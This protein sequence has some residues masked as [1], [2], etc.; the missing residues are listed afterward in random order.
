MRR[1]TPPTTPPTGTPPAP[2]PGAPPAG[3][4]TLLARWESAVDRGIEG[5]E[6]EG[7]LD[8]LLEAL[9]M[10]VA[11][12]AIGELSLAAPARRDALR[13]TGARALLQLGTLLLPRS[14]GERT[15]EADEERAE[16]VR[17]VAPYARDGLRALAGKEPARGPSA[18]ESSVGDAELVGLVRGSFDGFRLA[19][20]AW[21]VRDSREAQRALG[22]MCRLEELSSALE[23]GAT[24]RTKRA[25]GLR[26]AA[27]GSSS[28]R[29][30]AE[31]RRIAELRVGSHDV[32]LFRFEDHVVA[33]YAGTTV[34][35]R[36][37]GLHVTP[38]VT[39]AGYAEAR[40]EGAATRVELEVGGDRATLE[41]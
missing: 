28:V 27:D 16:A 5:F 2:P 21:R 39:R 8:G 29:D 24:A 3:A 41:L 35:L 40:L 7:Q 33:A 20:I 11:L 32:E 12:E 25:A 26:L 19:E 14:E 31:G 23:G 6:G 18:V 10:T 15:T 1:K 4:S 38:L 36:L 30:P 13:R 34:V 22:L 17:I 9:A 37:G